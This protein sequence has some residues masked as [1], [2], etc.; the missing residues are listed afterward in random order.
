MDLEGFKRALGGRS[1][2]FLL[3]QAIHFYER[4]KKKNKNNQDIVECCDN[5]IKALDTLD[6]EKIEYYQVELASLMHQKN[7][8]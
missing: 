8:K 2:K 5:L 3:R 4:I 7:L 6:Q 1:E